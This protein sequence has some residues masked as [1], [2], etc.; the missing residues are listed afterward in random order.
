MSFVSLSFLV[1]VAAGLVC[2]YIL[3]GRFQW[4]CLLLV[5]Y[6]FYF[7]AVGFSAVWLIGVTLLSYVTAL[8][9]GK[10]NSYRSSLDKEAR[11][12]FNPSYKRRKRLLV[13]AETLGC[14]GLLF[15]MKYWN[16]TADLVQSAAGAVLPRWDFLIPLGLSFFIFQSVGYVIDVSRGQEPERNPLKVALFTSFFPQLVQGPI[17]RWRNLS[18]QLLDERKLDWSNVQYGIQLAMWGYLKK[19]VIADRA[20]VAVI[21]VFDHSSAYGGAVIAASVFLYCIQLYCDFSGGID[22]ARGVARMFGIDMAENF[23]RPFFA[24]SLAD[25]WRRWHIT[26]GAW[27][28]DYL[29]YPLSLSA[30]FAKLGKWGRK[31]IGGKAGKILPTSLATFIVYLVIGLWHGANFRYIA[32]GLWNGVLITSSLLLENSYYTLRKRLNISDDNRWLH[33][34]RL[35]RTFVLVFIGRYL[36]RAPRLSVAI[37]MLWRTISDIRVYELW[38]GVFASLG[39]SLADL[40]IILIGMA[41]VIALELY[42][43]RGGHVRDTL[44]KQRPVVQWLAIIVPLGILLLLGLMR[45][46]YTA[47]EFIYKQF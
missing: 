44:A 14:F 16:F 35:C 26:L 6:V 1:L 36:T 27:M 38:N 2:Y 43:E 24:T 40:I 10:L 18:P 3:P 15:L 42:Q 23:R 32:F 45:E 41:I 12:S 8:A 9:L 37:D 11:K 25:Y 46:G 17:G 22:I 7:S 21:A 28:R 5:S 13:L 33:A 47:A 4:P 30:P 31:H 39:M 34:F 29:F 20:A 19:L